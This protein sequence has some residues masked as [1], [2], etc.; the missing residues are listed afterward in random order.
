MP[1]KHNMPV[2]E[3]AAEDRPRERFIELGARALSTAELL[4]ILIRTGSGDESVVSL[5]RRLLAENGNSLSRL[6]GLSV[7]QLCCYKGIGMTKAVTI[8]AALEIARRKNA[9]KPEDR[10][11]IRSSRDLYDYFYPLMADLNYEMCYALFVN[12]SG[13]A[14]DCVCVSQGGIDSTVVDVR[15][16]VR[17]AV[18][19][20][21]VAVAICHNHPSGNSRPSSADDS[22]TTKIKSACK[23]MDIQLLD[24]LIFAGDKY[25]SYTDNGRL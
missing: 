15:L 8:Q 4:A 21:A 7:Q 14:L 24:H 10:K 23:M 16:I 11:E 19:R 2:S 13:K 22:L 9:E 5:T 18:L 25:Y 17:E 20:H 12:Q 3:W 1:G 6:A